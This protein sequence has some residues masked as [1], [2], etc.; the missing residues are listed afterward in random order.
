MEHKRFFGLH[1]DFHAAE[2]EVGTRTVPEDIEWYI[3]EAKP[4]FIQCD[5]KGHEGNSS[6]PTKVGYQAPNIKSDNLRVWSDVAK[7]TNTPLYVHYSG[8]WD[9]RYVEAHPE[10]AVVN[11]NGESR[12]RAS[13]FGRY[14][15]DLL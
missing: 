9:G 5:S 14:C 8:V 11:E 10:E 12:G 3:N 7:K 6:Y 13:L 15:D 4:D 2:E 1:F